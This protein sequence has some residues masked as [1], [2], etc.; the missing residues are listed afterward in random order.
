[1]QHFQPYILYLSLRVEQQQQCQSGSSF[2]RAWKQLSRDRVPPMDRPL[3]NAEGLYRP[4]SMTIYKKTM[5]DI[6]IHMNLYKDLFWDTQKFVT[7]FNEIN[8][9]VSNFPPRDD[10]TPQEKLDDEK[11]WTS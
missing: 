11:S 6:H 1:M 3:K 2:I 5:E 10:G 8:K 4:Q 9:R 7:Q